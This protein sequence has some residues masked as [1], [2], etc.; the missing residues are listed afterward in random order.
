MKTYQTQDTALALTLSTCGVPFFKDSEGRECPFVHIYTAAILRKL[1]YKG[2][3]FEDAARTARERG[4]NG[5]IVYNFERTEL[6]ERII[7][8]YFKFSQAIA[9]AD[10]LKRPLET[11]INIDPIEAAKFG[12]QLLKNRRRFTPLELCKGAVPYICIDGDSKTEQED[13]KTVTIGSFKLLQ[14]DASTEIREHLKV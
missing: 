1:G 10:E 6:C 13:G 14:L 7:T 11:S 9:K 5:I 4:Q 8:A 2:I 12:C 3:P